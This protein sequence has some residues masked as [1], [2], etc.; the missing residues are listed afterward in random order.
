[1]SVRSSVTLWLV[2]AGLNGNV[3]AE[4]GLL[5]RW[6]FDREHISDR[7]VTPLAGKVALDCPGPP[8]FD[9]LSPGAMVFDGDSNRRF[10]PGTGMPLKQLQLPGKALTA[11]AWVRIDKPAEWGGLF[12]IIQDNGDYERGWLLGYRKSRFF[13]ALVS[14]KTRRVTY[15]QS[16]EP[17]E[18]GHWYHVVGT[19]DGTTLSLF[20][21]GKQ[22]AVSGALGGAVVYPEKGHFGVGAY[23]D[24]DEFHALTGQ[25]EQVS[26]WNRSLTPVQIQARFRERKSRFPGIE[27]TPP[28]VVDWPTHLRDNQ[29]TGMAVETAL[30]LPLHL[31]WSHQMPRP[32]AP[33]WP[34]PAQQDFWNQKQK[35]NPRVTFDRSAPLIAVGDAVY[36]ASS[37]GDNVTCLDLNTGQRRW[38]AFAEAPV[39]L[40]PAYHAGRVLFGSDD[41]CVYC[42]SAAD[43][44]G[45]WKRRIAEEDRRIMGNGRIIS[46]WPVRSGVLV[47]DQKVLC[48]AG[49]FPRQ[50][51][52]QVA[53]DFRTGEVLGRARIEISAQGYLERKGSRLHVATG[54]DPAGAFLSQLSRRGKGVD[55]ETR[56]IP[57]RFPYA[58]IGDARSRFGGGNREVAAFD[59]AGG[60]QVWQAEIQGRAYSLAISRHCLLVSTDTGMVYCF[61]ESPA[62]AAGRI[63]HTIRPVTWDSDEERQQVQAFAAQAIGRLTA[64]ESPQRVTNRE[65]RGWAVVLNSGDGKLAGEIARQ[66]QLNVVGVERDPEQIAVARERM[67]AAGL[68]G[69]VAFHRAAA[70][71]QLPYTDYLFNLIV[72]AAPL[73]GDPPWKTVDAARRITRPAGGVAIFGTREAD[74][75]R[76]KPLD[77]IGEW[78]HQYADAGNTACSQ[79]QR[80]RGAM[81]LQWFGAPG[82]QNLMDRHHRTA[83]PLWSGGRLFIPGNNRVIAAD[84]YNGTPLWDVEIPDSRR[85]GIYRDCSYLAATPQH[86]FVAA[87][88]RCEQREA[89]T[90]AI[91]R[92][93]EMPPL[94]SGQTESTPSEDMSDEWGYLAVVDGILFGS[95]QKQGASRRD[96]SREQIEEGTYFDSRPLVCSQSRFALRPQTEAV[97][98]QYQP[99]SGVIVN[100]TIAVADGQVS[101]L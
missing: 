78:T 77:G 53:L 98:W 31:Q 41:G 49:L 23:W 47:D 52:F 34:P 60:Q 76:R 1:M 71:G 7:S 97:L 87:G 6:Q 50:G 96:H 40:A 101:F 56:S 100:S 20:V 45:I 62:V 2:L 13:M 21:D 15:L 28:Q 80:V 92:R 35:L 43:G 90:G 5:Y 85:A 9:V 4:D 32:P 55:Q 17:F 66:S 91:R 94:P 75:Y 81:R 51:V 8:Q 10:F 22:S 16:R 70:D 73:S 64:A 26:L 67:E 39:R 54:R 58:F 19:W 86:V 89:T 95:R 69:R 12:G 93:L 14:E 29:R 11:A 74:V 42:V 88:S 82:P 59:A 30:Q 36:L 3:S 24:N 37:S 61:G 65:M 48:C 63:V 99:A 25:I 46:A 79:D 38:I 83:A 72:D 27:A 18:P 57:E 68:A 33:A 44:S 84:A